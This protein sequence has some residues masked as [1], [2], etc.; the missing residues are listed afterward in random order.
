MYFCLS[1]SQFTSVQQRKG[2]QVLFVFRLSICL[3]V[4]LFV[5]W[6]CKSCIFVCLQSLC[7]KGTLRL[8]LTLQN[9]EPV[10]QVIETVCKPVLF[11][12]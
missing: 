5:C 4:C 1:V 12:F 10:P 6:V 11:V 7:T 8:L 9:N 2:L 3:S